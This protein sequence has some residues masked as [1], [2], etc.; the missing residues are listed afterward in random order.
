VQ[1]T[2]GQA[3]SLSNYEGHLFVLGK[4]VTNKRVFKV[5]EVSMD[6]EGEVTIRAVEHATDSNGKSRIANGLAKKV[7]GLFLIDGMPE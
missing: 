1:V 2:N 3:P 6:E 5:T 4:R 7:P